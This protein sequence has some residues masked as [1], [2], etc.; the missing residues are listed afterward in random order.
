[1]PGVFDKSNA[2]V[3]SVDKALFS[4]KY[5][6]YALRVPA[7][8]CH[9]TRKAIKEH[10]LSIPR[11]LSVLK[12]KNDE[13]H[14]AVAP[15]MLL[16]LKYLSQHP[17]TNLVNSPRGNIDASLIGSA[18][19]EVAKNLR[20]LEV[21]ASMP[22]PVQSFL[23]HI[24][25]DD[26]CTDEVHI[27]YS[28]WPIEAVLKELT[29]EGITIPTSFESIGHIAHLNLREEQLPFK[30][31]I[32]EVMLD[33][34]GSRVKTIV[35]KL[36][37]TGG[38][39]R[40]FAMEVLAGEDNLITSVKENG[41]TFRMDF[42]KVYWN[43]RLETEH[44]KI[45]NSMKKDDIL[46]DAFCGIGPFTIPTAKQKKCKLVYAN[47]LNP[48]SVEY[49]RENVNL[50]KLDEGSIVTS[51][52]CARTFLTR[53]VKH[54]RI[55]ITVV[56]MNF[57]AGAPEFLDVFRGL[58]STWEGELPQMPLIYCYCFVRGTDDMQSARERTRMALC[59]H[60][61]D[62]KSVLPDSDIAVRDV[63]DVA[64]RKRQ[65]CVTV[66]VPREVVVQQDSV[67]EPLQKKARVQ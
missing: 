14:T 19:E 62:A 4:K 58:Y 32:G 22:S 18:K 46:A 7:K 12:P 37:N 48:S 38:P 55:P 1:M 20:E 36:E 34:L 28:H 42:S 51:C 43:S 61:D 26:I 9:G 64:P 44:R 29:P 53:L 23:K 3:T 65:V 2:A 8:L 17:S 56:V 60:M 6:V 45:I 39:Y 67:E 30:N 63:R 15:I 66:R 49:L 50:N 47:D 5:N 31:L 35:N 52:S 41:C 57:P 54:E 11:V 59:G 25:S 13:H 27:D 33:K 21:P 16:L 10:A 40:T 24:T